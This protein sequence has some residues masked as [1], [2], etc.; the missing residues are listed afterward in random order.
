[1][2]LCA[3]RIDGVDVEGVRVDDLFLSLQSLGY[4]DVADFLTA[5]PVERRSRV[6]ETGL[7]HPAVRI[8]HSWQ[9]LAP[10]PVPPR[11]MFCIGTNY[12]A[13]FDEGD[14]PADT[15]P[16][17]RPVVFTKPWT[18]LAGHGQ[19]VC[20]DPRLTRMVDWE[21]E[22]AVVVGR[23]GRDI[24]AADAYAHVFGLTLA[25]DLSARDVQLGEGNLNQWFLGKALD[26]FCPMGPEI[27]SLD[28]LEVDDVSF[29]LRVNGTQKQA[30]RLA[31]LVF[32]IPALIAFLSRYTALL[33]GDVILTGTPAGVG[34]WRKPQEFLGDGD[35]VTISSPQLGVLE[36][37]VRHVKAAAMSTPAHEGM[38]ADAAS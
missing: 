5:E 31:D 30:G 27:V 14:R 21:A 24:P 8:E 4:K 22:V 32:D 34:H 36:T 15:R 6:V 26:G 29:T 28:E 37:T 33:P 19:E 3:Y 9:L 38:V 16:P 7:G 35:V 12:R 18:T 13:H 17:V 10:V 25:N 2:R 23:G 11:N 1:M 20:V